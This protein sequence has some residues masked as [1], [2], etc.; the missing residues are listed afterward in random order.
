M[1]NAGSILV[2]P[3]IDMYIQQIGDVVRNSK[4]LP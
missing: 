2:F 3:N 4:S 1:R